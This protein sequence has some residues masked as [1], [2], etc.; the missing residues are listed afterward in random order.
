ML[1]M[2]V[3]NIETLTKG[4]VRNLSG[5]DR[6]LAAREEFGLDQLDESAESVEIRFPEDFRGISSSF[7]QGLFAE[8]VQRSGSV[9]GF[10]EHYRFAAPNHI[11]AQIFDYAEQALSRKPH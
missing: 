11:L 4:E 3:I 2:D 5:H 6:G 8:S 7:F 9:D 1:T 10:F